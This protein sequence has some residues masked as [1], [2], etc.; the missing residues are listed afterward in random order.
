MST[1][2]TQTVAHQMAEVVA[3]ASK[4]PALKA[5]L[6]ANPWETFKKHGAQ[7]SEKF[8][9]RVW[10]NTKDT[11][12][13][14]VPEE[15]LSAKD[16]QETIS[17]SSNI[18]Q[19]GRWII[20]QVQ[21]NTQYKTELLSHPLEVLRKQGIQVPT[22]FEL[23]IHQN[24]PQEKNIVIPRHVGDNEELSDFELEAVAGGK[25]ASQ[26]AGDVANGLTIAS[27]FM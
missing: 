19:I 13:L 18:S 23:K 11:Y 21:D 20:T 26:I 6:K 16:R 3:K 12:H 1:Q 15:D 27:F 2:A 7:V 10:E 24:T 17:S 22:N 8:K 5:E 25:G 4:D 14:V 9:L